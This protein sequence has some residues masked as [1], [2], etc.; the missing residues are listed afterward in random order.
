LNN[1][2]LPTSWPSGA[3]TT[4]YARKFFTVPSGGAAVTIKLAIDNDVQVFLDGMDIT[5]TNDQDAV[6]AVGG[7]L[8]HDGCPTQ[9]SFTFTTS[10]LSAGTHLLAIRAFDRGSSSY[11]DAEITLA[12]VIF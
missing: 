10:V 7:L 11:F 1:V 4:L 9:N 12:P 6:P 5:A 3:A 8:I 2:A